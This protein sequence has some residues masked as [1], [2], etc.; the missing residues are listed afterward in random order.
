MIRHWLNLPKVR[1]EHET[2]LIDRRYYKRLRLEHETSDST[3]DRRYFK[4]FDWSIARSRS[5][6]WHEDRLQLKVRLEHETRL[7]W[8]EDITKGSIVELVEIHPVD[9]QKIL[10]KGSWLE[11]WEEEQKVR[12]GSKYSKP[13]KVRLEHETR[14]IDTKIFQKVLRLEHET[15]LGLTQLH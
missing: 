4:R 2:R 13:K 1:L 5:V 15:R 6:N 3:V 12:F 14:L 7:D 8:R 9:W 11:H 10:Q